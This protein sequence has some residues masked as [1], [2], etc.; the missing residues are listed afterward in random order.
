MLTNNKLDESEIS[1]TL[2]ESKTASALQTACK[3]EIMA[4]DDS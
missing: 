2:R 3:R 1:Y 4:I